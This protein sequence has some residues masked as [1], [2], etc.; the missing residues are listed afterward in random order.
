MW[1]NKGT[2]FFLELTVK[3]IYVVGA[4]IALA[5]TFVTV[6]QN[7]KA[8]NYL[9]TKPGDIEFTELVENPFIPAPP[10]VVESPPPPAPPVV[11]QPIT[12]VIQRGDSLVKIAEAHGTTWQRLWNKNKELTHQ[13]NL[14]IGYTLVIPFP[15]EVLEERPVVAPVVVQRTYSGNS[16]GNTYARG[17]CTWHAKQMRPD[18]PNNLGNANTWYSRYTGPK[19]YAPAVGAIGV[20]TA[21]PLGHVVYITAVN[22]NG[23]VTVSEMNY[24]GRG[25]VS[26]RTTSASEFKYI[27]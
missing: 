19:G 11:P 14:T 27:Y 3:R 7:A 22:G 16:S 21:G 4:S 18:L 15:D 24:K 17:Y 1:L 6:N 26:T 12:Y 9:A 20:S 13:D 10:P 8:E 2:R 5:I 23:T 25:V